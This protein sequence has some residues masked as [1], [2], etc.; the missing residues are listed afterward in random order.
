MCAGPC[1]SPV[2]GFTFDAD[3]G[4]TVKAA[5]VQQLNAVASL[6]EDLP[7]VLRPELAFLVIE[8]VSHGGLDLRKPAALEGA[9]LIESRRRKEGATRTT[10]DR[11]R[12]AL[13][14][15]RHSRGV[16]LDRLDH[17]FTTT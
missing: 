2:A 5:H 15:A 12:G 16:L 11:V 6:M 9:Y 3:E 8:K 17:P 7:S 13:S 14:G 4:E 10:E 1:P